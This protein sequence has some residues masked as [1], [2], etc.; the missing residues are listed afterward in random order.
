MG[1]K[2]IFS[3]VRAGNL[4]RLRTRL[5]AGADPNQRDEA[6]RTPL[7]WAAQEGFLEAVR[8]LLQFGAQPNLTD[9]LGFSPL[10]VAA[11]EGH[12]ST[13]RELLSAGAAPDLRIP[14]SENGTPLHLACSWGRLGAA[15]AL[16][17]KSTDLNA[18]DASGKT[19]LAYAIEV[20]DPKLVAYLKK[21]GAVV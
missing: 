8:C 2:A 20:G 12:E 11:G 13:V 19:A 4:A 17:E 9:D 14:A 18:R 6:G 16:V 3:A 5:E 21:R 7:H 10:A 15:K 1:S